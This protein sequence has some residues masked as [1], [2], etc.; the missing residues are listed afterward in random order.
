MQICRSCEPLSVPSY[1]Y[2]RVA[3]SEGRSMRSWNLD[4]CIFPSGN[5]AC[6]LWIF[7]VLW[8]SNF[9]QK[10]MPGISAEVVPQQKFTLRVDCPPGG[11][12]FVATATAAVKKRAAA[13]VD[14][15]TPTTTVCPAGN[16][17]DFFRSRKWTTEKWKKWEALWCESLHQTIWTWLADLVLDTSKITRKENQVLGVVLLPFSF[18]T[19]V[20]LLLNLHTQSYIYIY[21]YICTYTF[22][23]MCI[24]TIQLINYYPVFNVLLMKWRVNL[25]E[26]WWI[27]VF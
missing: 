1:R 13:Q 22:I 14:V 25:I 15:P 18:G 2:M 24:Y 19:I 16:F 20:C 3:S 27:T 12:R 9:C 26:L 8:I 17:G 21:I 4:L 5:C 23:L 7:L 11:R 10:N 6:K